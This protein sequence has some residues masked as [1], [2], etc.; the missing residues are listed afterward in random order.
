MVGKARKSHGA[1]FELNSVFGLEKVDRWNPFRT[2][3][4]RSRSR[5]MRF[6]GFFNYEKG[7][8]R[9]EI[10][11][12]STVCSTFSRSGWSVVRIASLAKE[13]IS[14]KR[15]SPHL[16]K[17][18]TR[19]NKMNPRTFQTALV[20]RHNSISGYTDTLCYVMIRFD[21]YLGHL[22][23]LLQLHKL[24]SVEWSWRYWGMLLD[25]SVSWSYEPY[26]KKKTYLHVQGTVWRHE[27]SNLPNRKW[28]GGRRMWASVEGLN[29]FS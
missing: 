20:Q 22:T 19:S 5:S 12:S 2:S 28:E 16:H 21:W 13:S 10:L 11:K 3:A 9:Q 15:P 29:H 1:G 6:L 24:Y 8:P 26:F 7:D 27:F 18:P 23:R 4:I 25:G 14:K 17:V